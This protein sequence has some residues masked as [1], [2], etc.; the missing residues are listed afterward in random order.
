MNKDKDYVVEEIE[1]TV[2]ETVEQNDIS[3]EDT[4]PNKR[5]FLY[6]LYEPT[7]TL[8]TQ[9]NILKGVILSYRGINSRIS[10]NYENFTAHRKSYIK[11]KVAGNHLNVYFALNPEDYLGGILPVKDYSH[12]KKFADT[13]LMMKVKSNLSVRRAIELIANTMDLD[14]IRQDE[15]YDLDYY[16]IGREDAELLLKDFVYEADNYEEEE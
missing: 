1:E 15:V 4:K 8:K 2:V 5:P 13:P 11:L 9:Y 16:E 12:V 3:Y 7:G 10:S 6:Y 14:L